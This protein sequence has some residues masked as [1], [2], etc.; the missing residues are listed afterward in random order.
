MG[1]PFAV[2]NLF[3]IQGL[4][5]RAIDYPMEFQIDNDYYRKSDSAAAKNPVDI[6]R[7]DSRDMVAY[8]SGDHSLNLGEGDEGVGHLSRA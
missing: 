8:T 3:D 6:I 1:V 7:F 4:P 5:T 2:K